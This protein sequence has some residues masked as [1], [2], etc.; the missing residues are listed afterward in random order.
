MSE[1]WIS[2]GRKMCTYC[3][4]WI[5]DNKASINFHEQ[6]KNHK[7]NVKKKLDELRKKGLE[8]AKRKQ[9]E[10][11]DMEKIEKA[12]LASLKKDLSSNPT[13]AS[14]YGISED[15]FDTVQKAIASTTSASVPTKNAN[16]KKSD[17]GK[18]F[19]SKQPSNSQNQTATKRA[20]ASN[21]SDSSASTVHYMV[22]RGA[23]S[24]L[25]VKLF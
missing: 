24:H 10:Q 5:A 9:T 15:K 7:E 20:T 8:E 18:N 16:K 12:A 2:Q 13:M 11:S 4:C 3:K 23:Y 17:S 21:I 25:H 14:A 19:G 22:G 6:G 1:Y